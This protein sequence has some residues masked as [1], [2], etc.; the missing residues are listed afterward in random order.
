MRTNTFT[1]TELELSILRAAIIHLSCDNEKPENQA[2][3]NAMCDKLGAVDLD[4]G[5]H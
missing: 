5:R 3:I 4:G 2:A 1:F